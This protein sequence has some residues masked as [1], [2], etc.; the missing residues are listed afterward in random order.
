MGL[1]TQLCLIIL[2]HIKTFFFKCNVCKLNISRRLVTYL[3]LPLASHSILELYHVKNNAVENKPVLCFW[4]MIVP[5]VSILLWTYLLVKEEELFHWWKVFK[6]LLA[7]L[8][9]KARRVDV[10][11]FRVENEAILRLRPRYLF[12]SKIK[13]FLREKLTSD[14]FSSLKLSADKKWRKSIFQLVPLD[15]RSFL[16]VALKCGIWV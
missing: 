13:G 14:D 4:I 7:A 10:S 3:D 16:T 11:K 15:A 6:F 12:F 5:R 8:F 2:E 9:A 1:L